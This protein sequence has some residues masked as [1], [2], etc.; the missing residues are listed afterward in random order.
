LPPKIS[1][2]EFRQVQA[3]HFPQLDCVGSELLESFRDDLLVE[4]GKGRQRRELL[5]DGALFFTGLCVLD[6]VILSL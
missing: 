6:Y 3:I 1:L 4:Q 2:A 5:R